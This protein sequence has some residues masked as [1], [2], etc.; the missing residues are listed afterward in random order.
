MGTPVLSETQLKKTLS[1]KKKLK[2]TTVKNVLAA[3]YSNYWPLLKTEDT[4]SLLDLLN[5]HLT[6]I[7]PTKVNI[8]WSELKNIPRLDRKEFRLNYI[9]TKL[10]SQEMF[11]KPNNSEIVFGVN[12][13]T[14]LLEND[15]VSSILITGEVNPQIMVKHII[16]MA[17]LKKVPVLIIPNLKNTLKEKTGI[18]SVTIAFKELSMD[19]Q[20]WTIDQKIKE[21]SSNYAV[22][23]DH[24]NYHR[25]DYNSD[26]D[27][28]ISQCSP[29][30][31]D[32][33]SFKSESKPSCN[34]YLFRKSIAERAFVPELSQKREIIQPFNEL[35]VNSSGFL[36]FSDSITNRK[37]EDDTRKDNIQKKSKVSYKS[38]LIKRITNNKDRG[39]KKIDMLK[40]SK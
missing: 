23:Q 12:E 9:K 11:N 38:L 31:V 7:K 25:K 33:S 5:E 30:D 16:D 37:S 4:T 18:A 26:D 8:P 39:K 28:L 29:M 34:L 27:E 17:V 1:A 36:A 22:P 3:P 15:S 32:E 2:K 21:I 24:I 35:E 13:T 14:R 10:D 20:Y 19:S 6:K 40:R